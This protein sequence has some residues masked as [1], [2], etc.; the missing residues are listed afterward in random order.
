MLE[1][2]INIS[3]GSDYKLLRE[4]SDAGGDSVCDI[5]LDAIHNR[6]VLTLIAPD[7]MENAK[8]VTKKA[9]SIL[10]I[11]THRGLHPR[12]GV[13]DV[14]PF[15]PFTPGEIAPQSLDKATEYRNEFVAWAQK[16]LGLPCVTYEPERSLPETR[17]LL[18]QSALGIFPHETAG[19][20]CVGAR[21]LLVA[22]N[23]YIGEGNGERAKLIAG[24]IRSA[25]VRSLGFSLNGKE[26]VS[27]NLVDLTASGP[28]EAYEA[29][30]RYT[31]IT[32][33]ELV[34]LVPMGLL[35]QIDAG[36]WEKLDLAYEKSPEYRL[37]LS[38]AKRK[39]L[40]A[41]LLEE[42]LINSDGKS[43]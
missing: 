14:V 15:V 43:G 24:R 29:V 21:K 16:D 36:L 9:V 2:V 12:F 39:E 42:K 28:Q 23:I 11:T 31:E 1:C 10:D 5:H 27:C 20:A 32:G 34:G 19:V 37:S 40:I 3:E 22:Y 38:P 18:R 7:V 33:T 6:S 17:K 8:N 41:S 4:I 30:S 35:G 13:V 26:Q 25:S